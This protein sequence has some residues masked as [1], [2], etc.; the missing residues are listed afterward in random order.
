[1]LRE[2]DENR[3]IGE[4]MRELLTARMVKLFSE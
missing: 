2:G 1:M 3:R 4:G